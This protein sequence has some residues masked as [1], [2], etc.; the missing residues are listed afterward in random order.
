MYTPFHKTYTGGPYQIPNLLVLSSWGS[1]SSLS[2]WSY[3]LV[4]H[5]NPLLCI[6]PT[7]VYLLSWCLKWFFRRPSFQDRS[8]PSILTLDMHLAFYI[9]YFAFET[10]LGAARSLVGLWPDNL[11][12]S[13]MWSQILRLS[14]STALGLAGS[15]ISTV[16]N[17]SGMDILILMKLDGLTFVFLEPSCNGYLPSCG[18]CLL[19]PGVACRWLSVPLCHTVLLRNL[20][21]VL[22]K[23]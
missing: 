23:L 20:D 16:V 4:S 11:L 12:G 8:L 13:G 5:Q 6:F 15:T 1:A 9:R 21:G 10:W 18:T 3:W 17:G 19:H 14:M 22:W 7:R 2:V